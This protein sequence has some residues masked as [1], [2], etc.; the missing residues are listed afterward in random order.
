[1][2]GV[3]AR[4]DQWRAVR[5]WL[6][7]QQRQVEE[8]IHGLEAELAAEQSRRP[9]P[10]PPDWKAESI[11][12]A[13]GARPLRV[14]VGDCIMGNGKPIDR[15]QARRMLADNVEACPYCN[16]DNALGLME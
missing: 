8:K 5:A 2:S 7:W 9:L 11:R 3:Q 16:P 12:T 1:M 15:D 4:L 10:P 14:H 6:Q 13:A